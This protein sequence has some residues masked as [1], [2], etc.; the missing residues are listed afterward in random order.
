MVA[1]T[2]WLGK[3]VVDGSGVTPKDRRVGVCGAFVPAGW[4]R[5]REF[6]S[7]LPREMKKF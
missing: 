6:D 4:V 2:V 3:G 7:V 1:K 5:E